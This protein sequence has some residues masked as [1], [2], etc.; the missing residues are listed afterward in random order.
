MDLL[1]NRDGWYDNREAKKDLPGKKLPDFKEKTEGVALW[2]DSCPTDLVERVCSLPQGESMNASLIQMAE[3]VIA[4]PGNWQDMQDVI[5][6]VGEAKRLPTFKRTGDGTGIWMDSKLLPVALK[7][8]LEDMR[9][10][11]PKAPV[12]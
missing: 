7:Q 10:L 6:N 1:A 9:H 8:Q 2:L 4:N 3:D 5:D 11:V 12:T